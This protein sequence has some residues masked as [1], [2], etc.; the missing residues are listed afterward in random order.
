MNPIHRYRHVSILPDGNG[1]WARQ[2]GQ[3]RSFGH[4]AGAANFIG[5]LPGLAQLP[6]DVLS[7][8]L[9]STENWRRPAAEIDCIFR[10]VELGI[11]HN[12]PLFMEHN[13]RV[14]HIGDQHELPAPLQ[15]ALTSI[16]ATTQN[17][18]GLA[19][20]IAINYGGRNELVHAIRGMLQAGLPAGEVNEQTI[21][22]HLYLPGLPDPDI[23]VRTGGEYRLSNWMTWQT[24]HTPVKSLPVLWPDFTLAMLQ[25]VLWPTAEILAQSL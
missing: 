22:R 25:E 7:I 5:L 17:N 12:L 15:E 8:Y 16:C 1:R 19:L 11:A 23:I 20:V 10:A 24:A 6:M 3:A 21:R 2:H 14:Q 9:F 4:W 13:I 18:T